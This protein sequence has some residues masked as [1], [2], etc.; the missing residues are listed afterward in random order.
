MPEG[1]G[2]PKRTGKYNA[3]FVEGSLYGVCASFKKHKPCVV[4]GHSHGVF[5]VQLFL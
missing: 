1:A 3:D 4:V 2:D 5:S